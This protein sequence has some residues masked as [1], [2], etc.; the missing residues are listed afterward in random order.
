MQVT[1]DYHIGKEL[2]THQ[3]EGLRFLWNAIV[4]AEETAVKK[5]ELGD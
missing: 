2:Q 3:W 1:V 5:D 4:R